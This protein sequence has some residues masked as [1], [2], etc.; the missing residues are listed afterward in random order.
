MSDK[1]DDI[2]QA[3][4]DV[5]KLLESYD[6][7]TDEALEVL[8]VVI[9]GLISTCSAPSKEQKLNLVTTFGSMLKKIVEEE[10]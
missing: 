6:F 10:L 7:T 2:A 1:E 8:G 9:C 4:M 3:Q 5:I